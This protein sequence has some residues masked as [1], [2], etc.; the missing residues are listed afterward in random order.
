MSNEKDPETK[1]LSHLSRRV[2]VAAA[3]ATAGVAAAPSAFAK[4]T[5]I[6]KPNITWPL[7]WSAH[8]LA[9]ERAWC[10]GDRSCGIDS[11]ASITSRRPGLTSPVFHNGTM[12][13]RL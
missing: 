2:F 3:A 10:L 9:A 4:K 6:D 8:R 5:K 12:T 1:K 11:S 13:N 7:F